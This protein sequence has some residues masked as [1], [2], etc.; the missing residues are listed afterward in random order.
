MNGKKARD[1]RFAAKYV[2][3]QK[4][5]GVTLPPLVGFV[6][7]FFPSLIDAWYKRKLPELRRKR[8]R[9]IRKLEKELKKDF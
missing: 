6:G 9:L 1:I 2:A 5:A 8:R 3:Y 4:L 7:R